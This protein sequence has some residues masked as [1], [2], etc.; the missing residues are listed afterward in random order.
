MYP[1]LCCGNLTLSEPGPGTFDICPECG[2]E[3][4]TVTDPNY[5]GGA[6]HASRNEVRAQYLASIGPPLV[7]LTNEQRARC[8]YWISQEATN[9]RIAKR[10]R[11]ILLLEQKNAPLKVAKMLMV[12]TQTVERWMQL[13]Q[14]NPDEFEQLRPPEQGPESQ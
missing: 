4:D 7:V 11:A 8:E 1:C 14:T 2:W 5:A 10:H 6:N 12:K 9:P 13:Y 3:D